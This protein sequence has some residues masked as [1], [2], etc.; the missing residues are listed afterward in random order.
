MFFALEG[1]GV[2]LLATPGARIRRTLYNIYLWLIMI[3]E[4]TYRQYETKDQESWARG[5]LIEEVERL[6]RGL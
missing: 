2:D 4:C 3:I 6:P 1:Y 5:K